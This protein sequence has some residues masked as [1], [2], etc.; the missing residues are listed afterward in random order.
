MRIRGSC[1]SAARWVPICLVVTGCGAIT[2]EVHDSTY[3]SLS[4]APAGPALA[5]PRA[6]DEARRVGL[7]AF[8]GL[9]GE[10]SRTTGSGET[11]NISADAGGRFVGG[12]SPTAD[13][14]LAG[15]FAVRPGFLSKAAARDGRADDFSAQ[16]VVS[17]AFAMRWWILDLPFVDLGLVADLGLDVLPYKVRTRIQRTDPDG[18]VT[19]ETVDDRGVSLF[20]KARVGPVVQL[21]ITSWLVLTTGATIG[22]D[23]KLER[24]ASATRKCSD[25]LLFGCTGLATPASPVSHHTFSVLPFVAPSV[26]IGEKVSLIVQLHA[27]LGDEVI[28]SP[29]P[30]GL[31]AGLVLAL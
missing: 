28:V 25:N 6:I 16:F 7:G 10:P 8:A 20:P 29:A 17:G 26:R 9:G 14:E 24:H 1:A 4:A 21:E 3:S 11:G 18:T 5:G 31:E 22:N 15:V 30:Y 13:V 19:Y 2:T 27:V 23:I 12:A